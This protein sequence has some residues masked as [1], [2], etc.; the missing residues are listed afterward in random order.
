MFS[1]GEHSLIKAWN[2][3]HLYSVMRMQV[4]KAASLTLNYL[5]NPEIYRSFKRWRRMLSEEKE[6]LE[7]M[8]RAEL[9]KLLQR[10]KD[11]LEVEYS[12]KK[13]N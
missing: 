13:S 7:N 3:V 5:R 10:Q 11:K 6:N 1:N 4:R 12:K 8:S 9:I 2:T